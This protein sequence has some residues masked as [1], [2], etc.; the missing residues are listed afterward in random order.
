MIVLLV[1]GFM[2]LIDVTI[3][4]VALPSMQ[5]AFAASDSQIEWVVAAYILVFALGL[6]PFGRTGD[7]LGR[8]Q[9]FLGGICV[10]TIGSALCGLAPSMGTLIAARALQGAGGAMMIPQTLALTPVLF[11]PH[12]RGFAFSLFG[13]TAGLASVAG[14]VI[15]GLLIRADILELGWRP[16]FLVNVPIGIAAV[17]ATLRFVPAP[18]GNRDIGVDL[19]GIALAAATLLM[20]IVPLIEGRQLGWPVWCLLMIG[21]SLPVAAG[22][23]VWEH[24]QRRRGAPELLPAAL[25]ESRNFLIGAAMVAALFSGIPGFFLVLALYLQNGY[26][27]DPLT[28]GLTTLPFPVGVFFAS[29]LSGQLGTRWPR[30][31]ITAGGLLLV[32]GMI[33][34]RLAVLGTDDALSRVGFIPALLVGGLGLG[35]TVAML[36]Q[37]VL[38][39]VPPRDTGSASGALQAF[40][41]VGAAFGVAIIGELFFSRLAGVMATGGDPHAAYAAAMAYAVGYNILAFVVVAALAQVLP[42]PAFTT[43]PGAAVAPVPVD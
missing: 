19:V 16:I 24:R 21:A 43:R 38:A 13:L 29:L 4:N 26:G 20:L 6:L 32:A 23:V 30:R 17:F 7:M 42:K 1:A 31:R 33:W 41:Q 8:R 40:Q 28:S 3:V 34:L 12:E 14:P 10:F 5:R 25:L 9:M 18:K 11:P 36:F 15:G 27:L 39:T 35:M 22:F 37:T 2:N